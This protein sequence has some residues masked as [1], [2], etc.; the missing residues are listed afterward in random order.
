MPMTL[1]H[2]LSAVPHM[3]LFG[4]WL[5]DVSG[6]VLALV[7]PAIPVKSPVPVDDDPASKSSRNAILAL[8]EDGVREHI[9]VQMRSEF[10]RL[11][12][13]YDWNTIILAGR[14]AL[15][16]EISFERVSRQVATLHYTRWS[17]CRTIRIRVWI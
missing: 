13:L 9:R 5:A 2:P 6:V 8:V 11:C 1:E 12:G 7:F 14:N 3:G 15:E 16:E 10:T 17:R 4:P